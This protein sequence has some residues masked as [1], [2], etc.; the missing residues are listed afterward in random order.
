[1]PVS[2]PDPTFSNGGL[3]LY[4]LTYTCLQKATS[5]PYTEQASRMDISNFNAELCTDQSHFSA[6]IPLNYL[7][8]SLAF[9]NPPGAEEH[10]VHTYSTAVHYTCHKVQPRFF[11]P[12]SDHSPHVVHPKLYCRLYIKRAKKIIRTMLLSHAHI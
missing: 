10:P 3:D 9:I 7:N 8:R 5:V 12:H 11:P 1:M 2:D 4:K 6:N